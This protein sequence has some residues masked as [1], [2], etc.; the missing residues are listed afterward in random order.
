MRVKLRS[1]VVSVATAAMLAFSA[2]GFAANGD[3][4]SSVRGSLGASLGDLSFDDGGGILAFALNAIFALVFI[5]V[6]RRMARPAARQSGS[7]RGTYSS[8]GHVTQTLV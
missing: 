4:S 6:A 7:V 8:G 5:L 3:S 1:I 2:S